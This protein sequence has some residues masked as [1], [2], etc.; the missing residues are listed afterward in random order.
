MP[1]THL[2]SALVL[3][4][5]TFSASALAAGSAT[6]ADL[7]SGLCRYPDV[8]KNEI[9]FV[10]ANDLWIA[11]KQGGAARPLASPRGFEGSPRFS[12]DGKSIA[13]RGNYDQGLDLY[14]ISAQ[15]GIPER[16]THHPAVEGL[17]DWTPDGAGLIFM[18][19]GID[20]LSRAT[21]LYSV[22]ASGGLPAMLPVPYGANGSLDKTG[23]WLAYT[24]H[25]TDNRT[26][27]RYRGGMATDIWLFNVK[28]GESKRITDWEGTDTLPMWHGRTVYYL[29]DEGAAEGHVL[30]IWSY[31]LDTGARK[32]VSRFKEHDVKWP[33]IG[34]DDGSGGEIVLQ[35]GD[36]IY[37][38]DLKTNAA[39]IVEI[40]V[41]GDRQSLRPTIVD[42]AE[43][44]QGTSI[45]PSGKRVAVVARGDIWTA[46]AE[47][48]TPRNLTRTDGVFERSATWS[49]DGKTIAFF[50]DA[51]GEY[52]LY[53]ISADGTGE[54]RQVTAPREGRESCFRTDIVWS[55]DSKSVV[56]QDKAGNIELVTLED[57][58]T[59]AL[60]KNPSAPRVA[61]ISFSHDSRWIAWS[62][63]CDET[64]LDAI[65][66][67]DTKE[68]D[69]AKARTMVTSGFY[70]DSNPT[71]DRKG[72]WL[73]FTSRRNFS[74]AYSEFDT[75][76]IYNNSQVLMAVPLKKE[77]KLPWLPTSDEEGQKDD[78]KKDDAKPAGGDGAPAA[79]APA[80]GPAEGR[81]RRRTELDA[82][83]SAPD[84]T[85]QE[86]RDAGAATGA[87]GTWNC[88]VKVENAPVAVTLV[89]TE[90]DGEVT[91]KA[92]SV[93]GAAD[94]TGTFDAATGALKLR[95][96]VNAMSFE[97]DLRVAGDAISGVARST[98]E[99]GN[100]VETEFT[101]TRAATGD[102]E[103]KDGANDEKKDG[104]KKD[105]KKEVVIDLDGFEARAV[106]LP[107]AAGSFGSLGFNDRNELLYG[108][109]GSV[110][111]LDLTERNPTEKTGVS[112]ARFEVS[113]DGKK[114]LVG[115][116]GGASI[117]GSGAGATA[118]PIVTSPML[119]TVDPRAE[120]RQ[121]LV[122]AWRIFRDYF[123][124][125]GMHG[126]D[127]PAIRAKYEAM[128]PAVVTRE[129]LNYLIAEMIS[130]LNAGHAYLQGPGD[131]ETAPSRSVGML[132][133]EF[134]PALNDDGS[135]A[136][137]WKIARFKAGAAFDNT[138]RSPLA[139]Q[140]LGVAEGDY[141]LAVNGV[142]IDP[143]RDPWSAFI[144]LADRS[145]VL[146]VSKKP[147]RDGDARDVV[148][149]T[150]SSEDSLNYRSW[151]ESKRRRVE[152][153]SGGKIGYI[154][155]PNTGVDG[156]TELVRQFYGQRMKP[157]LLIDE[158]WNG[159][160]Q[161]PTR[162]IELLNRPVTNYWARR[163]ARDGAWPPDGHR[164]P[165]AM[166][167]NGLAGSGGDM[168]PWLFQHNKLGPVIGTRTWGG[169]IGI[170]GNP[171]LLD[172]G[173]IA[174]PTFGFYETD[175]TW[176]VEGHGIDPDIEVI[177]D[178]AL[179]KDGGDPQLEKAVE[180]LLKELETNAYKPVPEPKGPNRR[181]MGLPDSDK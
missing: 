151:V 137:A 34:P 141:L 156:Q 94:L 8:S 77:F 179:M 106:Q 110:R 39:R 24:P 164:G 42:A 89:L 85:M 163:D 124:E 37:L 167:V 20:G 139:A 6:A 115:G 125:A 129:D 116:R 83:A 52:E 158:R 148:V 80:G 145:V 74:P 153:L 171:S 78:A 176:G 103:K 120:R 134:A 40:T 81:R 105:D 26:W 18:A 46:P 70:S 47:N 63:S 132:G 166:L 79:G 165:K 72:E 55:P 175:G 31:S 155:V 33:A 133:V 44:I 150:I 48:G 73:A 61:P 131:V 138:A 104:D 53:T 96:A 177:D 14:T 136:K 170:S 65:Y 122:D 49:P 113:A 86:E 126:V 60:D 68:A 144:G 51:T 101:G 142:D 121:I 99:E 82:Q 160:G 117:A 102:G 93:M 19:S 84:S 92:T 45:S 28:T 123:Y 10:Y 111:I 57:G 35:H 76:W 181:G 75:T 118:K 25:S 32:Q 59:V 7:A 16:V 66:L 23:E 13:F 149:T 58:A 114:L 135:P 140:G 146:T 109:D 112:G 27:K 95:G 87:S 12:P 159:G 98:D 3:V 29:S 119:V 9:V 11:P 21:K 69:P 91:G 1:I 127:W 22:P 100:A 15:G 38:L 152:D 173:T 128:L 147:V 143:T 4:A 5:T 178:P 161:I 107:A 90:R 168:F 162:F 97:L 67:H 62:R 154:Y 88:V 130:E 41:P 180:V 54:P 174:V 56:L 30:N 169:L 71:F 2:C 108:R 50:S 43:N 172:G 64:E 17:C 157:A 36:S